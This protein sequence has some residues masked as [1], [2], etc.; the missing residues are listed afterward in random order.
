[1]RDSGLG[2]GA[3]EYRRLPHSLADESMVSIRRMA[4]GLEPDIT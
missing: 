4:I 3:A 2:I 1:M